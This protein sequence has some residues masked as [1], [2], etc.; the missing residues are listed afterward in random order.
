MSPSLQLRNQFYKSGQAICMGEESSHWREFKK[1]FRTELS[2]G[3]GPGR[4]LGYGF[5]ESD[6]RPSWLGHCLREVEIATKLLLLNQRGLLWELLQARRTVRKMGLFFSTD[7]FR[8]VCTMCLLKTKLKSP[9]SAVA[10]IGDGPGIMG[11]L[12]HETWPSARLILIDLG[13]TLAVQAQNLEKAYP[14]DVHVVAG[15]GG[16]T[17][18][19]PMY[20]L[21]I[22]ATFP[23]ARLI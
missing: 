2:D 11:A 5:G 19:S 21:K 22:W 9:P 18:I 12:I 13:A 16:R 6:R 8:H 3:H 17:R 1:Q 4:I 7:A 14:K 10:L 20:Q 15:G 23:M